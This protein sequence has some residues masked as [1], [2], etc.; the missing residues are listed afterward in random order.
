MS[1]KLNPHQVIAV[2]YI[3]NAYGLL[4]FHSPGSGKTITSLK[5]AEQFVSHKVLIITTKSSI[6][7]F[8]DDLIKISWNTNSRPIEFYTYK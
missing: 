1:I 7:A 5:M 3:R 4:L 8:Q 2:Q 6:K